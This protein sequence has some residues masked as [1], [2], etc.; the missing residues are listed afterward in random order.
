MKKTIAVTLE[1]VAEAVH[2]PESL[3][4]SREASER[5]L[6]IIRQAVGVGRMTRGRDR[7]C[8]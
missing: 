2:L 8:C 3:E 7:Q 1:G 6:Q 5:A 4:L